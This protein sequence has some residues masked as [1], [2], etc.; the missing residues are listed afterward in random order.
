MI[1]TIDQPGYGH[2]SFFIA[3]KSSAAIFA[4]SRSASLC[5]AACWKGIEALPYTCILLS[6][7]CCLISNHCI[8]CIHRDVCFLW[9]QPVGRALKPFPTSPTSITSST[10]RPWAW[11]PTSPAV[12]LHTA[13]P[14]PRG[15][16]GAG[17]SSAPHSP[18][19]R[20]ASD[21]LRRGCRLR[22]GRR[23]RVSSAG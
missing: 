2:F 8:N 1:Q 13:Y 7:F 20:D 3:H 19:R 17:R 22:S 15:S 14:P 5:S 11:P 6:A 16:P 23:L 12:H 10:A 21:L 4:I 9:K 18:Y